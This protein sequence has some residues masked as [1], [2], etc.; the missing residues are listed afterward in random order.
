MILKL[1]III[2]SLL[3]SIVL[4]AQQQCVD[5]SLYHIDDTAEKDS[6]FD[7]LSFLDSILQGKYFVALGEEEHG[8]GT[9]FEIKIQIVKYLHEKLGFNVIAFESGFYDCYKAWQLIQLGENADTTMGKGIYGVWSD[10]KQMLPMF[11]YVE[12]EKNT[13]QPLVIAGFDFQ[14]SGSFRRGSLSVDSLVEDLTGFLMRYKPE[15]VNSFWWKEFTDE[16]QARIEYRP[17]KGEKAAQYLNIIETSLC[18]IELNNE[19]SFWLQWIKSTKN[20]INDPSHRDKY[21]A[22]NFFWLKNNLYP[23]EKIILW[24]ASLHFMYNPKYLKQGRS[25]LLKEYKLPMG[26]YL[27]KRYDN[28]LYAIA[29]TAFE[30]EMALAWEKETR[31]LYP[32]HRNSIEY[33]LNKECKSNHCFLDFNKMIDSCYLKAKIINSRAY[34]WNTK[35]RISMLMDGI[36]FH[37]KMER[38]YSV[39]E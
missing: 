19:V 3:I 39:F 1:P 36:I 4:K 18:E 30:G 16:L 2:I 14:F 10:S 11:H 6:P 37:K 23:N 21:M 29:S 28:E 12:K 5:L 7:N 25:Y 31:K 34:G 32:A 35:M 26:Y 8:A 15:I 27:K 33:F 38:S 13:I 17:V 24:G 9:T 22:E 20:F